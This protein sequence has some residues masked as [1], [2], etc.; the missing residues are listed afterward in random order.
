M[1]CLR[2]VA[3]WIRSAQKNTEAMY[4]N[5][6]PHTASTE[7]RT[8]VSA[9]NASEGFARRAILFEFGSVLK[10]HACALS[11][12]AVGLPRVSCVWVCLAFLN[13]GLHQ[14]GMCRQKTN[15]Y[16]RTISCTL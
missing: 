4:L 5:E 16:G 1:L 8:G 10:G 2:H 15:R 9:Q 12:S 11:S 6:I 14:Y 7:I 3:H 13:T